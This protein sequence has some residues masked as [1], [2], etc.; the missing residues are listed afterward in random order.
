[1]QHILSAE[2]CEG[3]ACD[4]G[5]CLPIDRRCNMLSECANSEDEANCTCADFLKAQ[6]LH[7]KICDGTV[8]CFDYTDESDCGN[9]TTSSFSY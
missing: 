6:L 5:K 4:D 1:M 8:D 2:D 9:S 7:K 3:F